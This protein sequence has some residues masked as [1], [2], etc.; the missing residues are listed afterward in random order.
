MRGDDDTMSDSLRGMYLVASKRLRDSN[1]YKTVVLIIEDGSEGS[2]GLVVNRPSSVTV[3]H[4]LSEHFHLP[5]TDDQVYV[6]G[7][8][9]PSALFILHSAADL[10]TEDALVLPGVYVGSSADA[11]ERIVRAASDGDP[12]L[13]FR[14]FSGC[15]GWAPGQLAGELER[16]D[17][18]YLP[19]TVESLFDSDPYELWNTTRNRYNDLHSIL[20]SGPANPEWN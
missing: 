2:M 10:E 12:E 13:R 15:A 19:A 8:V 1:F 9:E 7:P 6:G 18:I 11:F 14:I 16:G 4:A 5:E 3:A 17:W 20:P